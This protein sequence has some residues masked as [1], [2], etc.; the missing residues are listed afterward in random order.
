[1][2]KRPW[3]TPAEVK[4][5]T[6]RLAV[7]S[8]GDAKLSVDITRAEQ[9]VISY[10][11]NSFDDAKKYL[12]V[13]E[14]VKTAV[15]LLAEAYAQHAVEGARMMKSETF[16]DYSYTAADSTIDIDSLCLG[17]LLDDYVVVAPRQ[18]VTM[19]IRRL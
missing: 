5:Y 16:D 15:I 11:N 7:Q 19:K 8:R 17:P 10:T 12:T 9:Y 4:S 1:M 18:G 14:A 6:D 3:V 2:A 13:P